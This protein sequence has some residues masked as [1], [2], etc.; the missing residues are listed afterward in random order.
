MYSHKQC[1]IACRLAF[2]VMLQEAGVWGDRQQV[3]EAPIPG[4]KKKI[5][6]C[7]EIFIKIYLDHLKENIIYHLLPDEQTKTSCF[8]QQVEICS[9]MKLY[10]PNNFKC[11]VMQQNWFPMVTEHTIHPNKF[12]VTNH[13][14][15]PCSPKS[16]QL[17]V[18]FL[19]CYRK[20]AEII[21][22]FLRPSA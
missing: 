7:T 17:S 19:S 14:S 6:S 13:I 2:D 10:R 20:D 12:K 9:S 4:D 21:M 15:T 18:S 22:F 11:S 8:T 5:I 3:Q 1:E 16:H